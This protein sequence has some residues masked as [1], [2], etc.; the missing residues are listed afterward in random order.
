MQSFNEQ[1]VLSFSED[2]MKK[3]V[4]LSPIS[5]EAWERLCKLLDECSFFRANDRC[6]KCERVERCINLWDEFVV[7][8]VEETKEKERKDDRESEDGNT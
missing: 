7:G 1:Y 8:K 3:T 2:Y 5:I 4:K 6:D